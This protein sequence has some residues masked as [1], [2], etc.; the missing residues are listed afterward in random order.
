MLYRIYF[1][2]HCLLP[3]SIDEGDQTTEEFYS[4]VI[5]HT[6]ISS[7]YTGEKSNPNSPVAWFETIGTLYK[8]GNIAVIIEE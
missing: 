8:N 5:C 7:C 2:C 3:W 4:K 6:P 1:N